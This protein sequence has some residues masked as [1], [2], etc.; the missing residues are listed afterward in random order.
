MLGFGQPWRLG[1]AA[2][3][4]PEPA[5]SQRRHRACRPSAHLR[6][7]PA[8]PELIPQPRPV[9]GQP[10]GG[11][12]G[13]HACTAAQLVLSGHEDGLGAAGRA[14]GR[15]IGRE[16]GHIAQRQRVRTGASAYRGLNGVGW[17]CDEM[18]SE[19]LHLKRR[20]QVVSDFGATSCPLTLVASACSVNIVTR[21]L[22]ARCRRSSIDDNTLP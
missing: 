5:S 19:W 20:C 16:N 13:H 21:S 15:K 8:A 14:L 4:Q 9:Q 11:R 6:L 3:A 18:E 22:E 12:S 2:D 10:S 17:D 7:Y 1:Q